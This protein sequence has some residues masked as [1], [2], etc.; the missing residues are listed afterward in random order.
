MRRLVQLAAVGRLPGD[1]RRRGGAGDGGRD[2]R[3]QNATR[4]TRGGRAG[5]ARAADA[6]GQEGGRDVA[7][8]GGRDDAAA[9]GDGQDA[10][11]RRR[12]EGVGVG[13]ARLDDELDLSAHLSKLASNAAAEAVEMR[14]ALGGTVKALSEDYQLGEKARAAGEGIAAGV[15]I[16]AGTALG[17]LTSGWSAFND[18]LKSRG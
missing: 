15:E 14:E 3:A 13:A 6:G 5:A 11:R 7:E 17:A 2:G 10:G 1:G 18:M 9:G 4:R 16:A 8:R 12:A